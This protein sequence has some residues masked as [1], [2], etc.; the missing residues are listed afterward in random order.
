MTLKDIYM[1]TQ[2]Q[3][4]GSREE[5][6][7]MY[8]QR[9]DWANVTLTGLV[10]DK[11][12]DLRVHGGPEKALHQFSLNSYAALAQQFPAISQ[13]LVPGSMGE[14]LSVTGMD[15]TNVCIGDIYQIGACTVQVSQPRQP[16]Y[17]I[18]VRFEQTGMDS[19]VGK[20]GI[21]GWYYR[22]LTSGLIRTED[23]VDLLERL[24][25]EVRVSSVMKMYSGQITEPA[26]I[27]QAI[28]ASGFNEKWVGKLAKR[29]P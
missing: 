16:C 6:T 20:Q 25:P 10:G 24:N 14:N 3:P 9:V 4:L 8:K 21:T 12:G 18:G 27:Q 17:K 19:F 7:G 13:Q 29:L 11:Q 26:L 28:A 22:V 2:L 23:P 5:L 1:A 15:D